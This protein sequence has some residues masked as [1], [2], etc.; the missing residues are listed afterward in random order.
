MEGC[1]FYVAM[2]IQASSDGSW[3]WHPSLR[4]GVCAKNAIYYF[5]PKGTQTMTLTRFIIFNRFY[6]GCF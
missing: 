2:T 4:K 3:K 1:S 6:L 5:R